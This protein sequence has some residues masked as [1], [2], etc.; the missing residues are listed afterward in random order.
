[1]IATELGVSFG[2]RALRPFPDLVATLQAD[3]CA[4]PVK[5]KLIRSEL[6]LK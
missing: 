6:D 5:L 4:K 2:K 1:M 3:I